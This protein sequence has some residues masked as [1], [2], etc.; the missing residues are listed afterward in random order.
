MEGM[1]GWIGHH[2]GTQANAVNSER[3]MAE[4]STT[5]AEIAQNRATGN[6][7]GTRFGGWFVTGSRERISC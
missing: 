4:A 1:A 3:P 6:D 5:E 7:V 2:V